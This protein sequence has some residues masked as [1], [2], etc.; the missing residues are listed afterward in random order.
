MFAQPLPGR[1]RAGRPARRPRRRWLLAVALPQPP[2]HPDTDR[3]RERSDP[4]V[5][6]V[7]PSGLLLAWAVH[8]LEKV[9]TFERWKRT[10]VPRLRMRF[11]GVPGLAW[12][13][14][15]SASAQ[16]FALAVAIVGVL[17][18]TASAAGLAS[19][20]R[21]RYFQLMLAGSGCTPS[22]TP[23]AR[24]RPVATRPAWSPHRSSWHHSR[25]GRCGS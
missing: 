7:V 16:D 4:P 22:A 1:L 9:L 17:M 24:W 18:T 5:T 13:R 14:L 19:G 10:A 2:A 3:V 23:P 8:D 11:P 6:P 21:S 12:Q 25:R 20:G 15:E